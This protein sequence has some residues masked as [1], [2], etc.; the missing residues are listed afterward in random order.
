MSQVDVT[1]RGRLVERD[2]KFIQYPK[3]KLFFNGLRSNYPKKYQYSRVQLNF[4]KEKEK[5]EANIL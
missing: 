5:K 4:Q 3:D 2:Y 1:S